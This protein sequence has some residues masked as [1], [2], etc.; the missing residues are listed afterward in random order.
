[1]E[2]LASESHE[3]LREI[4]ASDGVEKAKLREHV[5]VLLAH[6]RRLSEEKVFTLNLLRKRNQELA[7]FRQ[8]LNKSIETIADL[9]GRLLGV[10]A[11]KMERVE[12]ADPDKPI[13][14]ELIDF[15]KHPLRDLEKRA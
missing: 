8:S 1:M 11:M 5:G 14:R 3:T 13:P 7:D 9:R 15:G 6:T 12:M 4:I 2:A 10:M